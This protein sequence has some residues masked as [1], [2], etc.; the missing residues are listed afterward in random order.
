MTNWDPNLYLQFHDERTQ[1]SLDLIARIALADAQTIIDLGCG[2]GNSTRALRMR[3]QRA[4]ITGI[5]NSPQMIEK[6][7]ATYPNEMWLLADAGA[8]SPAE[9]CD[10]VFSN[11]T[12][13]WIPDH[14]ALIPR[15]CDAVAPGGVLAV[16]VPAN[17]QSPLHQALLRVSSKPEWDSLTANCRDQITY[18]APEYYYDALAGRV[19][20]IELWQTTYLHIMDRPQALIDWYASTGMKPYLERLGSEAEKRQFQQDVLRECTEAYPVRKD[21]RILFAFARTFFV[22]YKP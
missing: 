19:K 2:P 5:D 8:W 22:A 3:W 11:A 16:Q 14:D 1:P 7:R 18:H 4:R 6:A 21:G 13:Q 10:L 17:Q 20:R 9:P 12:L 15:L